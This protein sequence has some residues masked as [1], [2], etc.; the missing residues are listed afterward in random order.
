MM[1]ADPGRAVAELVCQ[2]CLFADLQHEVVRRTRIVRIIVVGECEIPEIDRHVVS[3]YADVLLVE[4]FV[5]ANKYICKCKFW[6][7]RR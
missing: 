7:G 1:F 5:I 3:P 6:G 4:V 2:N